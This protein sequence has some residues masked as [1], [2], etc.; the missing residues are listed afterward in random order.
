MGY[1]GGGGRDLLIL[2]EF[3]VFMDFRYCKFKINF[4]S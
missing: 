3:L 2:K 1:E 4:W